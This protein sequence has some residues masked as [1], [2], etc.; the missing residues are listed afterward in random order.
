[1][2]SVDRR[3]SEQQPLVLGAAG[4]LGLNLVDALLAEGASPLCGRRR[5][6]NVIPLRSRR[7]DMV[8]TELD[9]PDT[10]AQA[11]Q[12]VELVFHAAGHY[13]RY[14]LDPEEATRVGVGRLRRSL[15]AAAEA[16]VRRLVYLS[17][18]ATVAPTGTGAPSDER[19]VFS[20]A[21]GLGTYHDLKWTMEQV[22]LAER[23]FE[24]V[25]A[26]AAG[27]I[28]PWDL[29]VGTSA[30]LVATARGD[31]PPHPD[32]VI[33]MVDSRDVGQAM[34]RL[35]MHPEPPRRVILSGS[36]HRFQ[37][38]LVRMAAHYGV[39]PPSPPLSAAAALALADA[40]EERASRGGPRAGLSREIADLI[41][42]GV[43]VDASLAERALG[44]KWTP[45]DQTIDAYDAWARRMKLIPPIRT[46]EEIQDG[47]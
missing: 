2:G 33:N 28:G 10:L 32:G 39:Q 47:H 44:M 11:M 38:L 40:E 31:D 46:P 41:V 17:S 6:E 3:A 23:R 22:A 20:S 8:V 4:F 45:L 30:L 18:T 13:P 16:G 24:V 21:P 35:G 5:R 43:P 9:E 42:H 26:C 27:C 19:H 15:D 37:E 1:V 7:A 12:G 29:R 34:M 25:V 14:S 36:T